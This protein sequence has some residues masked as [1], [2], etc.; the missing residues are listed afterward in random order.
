MV[1]DDARILVFYSL[2]HLLIMTA[3]GILSDCAVPASG[4]IN[5][6]LFES[7]SSSTPLAGLPPGSCTANVRVI[8]QMHRI[9]KGLCGLLSA[10]ETFQLLFQEI[11]QKL[12]VFWSLYGLSVFQ[13][14]PNVQR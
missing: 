3:N 7:M 9:Y 8:V 10:R 11:D 2:T 1:Q 12:Y 5:D 6:V 14:K 4:H 13:E